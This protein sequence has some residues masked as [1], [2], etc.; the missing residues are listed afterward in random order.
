MSV[1]GIFLGQL[2][3]PMKPGGSLRVWSVECG[4]KWISGRLSIWSNLVSLR[5][6]LPWMRTKKSVLEKL[7]E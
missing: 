6:K 1:T 7:E 5:V 2:M 4:V 3:G